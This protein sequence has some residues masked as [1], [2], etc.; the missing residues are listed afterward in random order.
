MHRNPETLTAYFSSGTKLLLPSWLLGF[1]TRGERDT[2][3]TM[4][5]VPT[6]PT[7]A[8]RIP[9]VTNWTR[10]VQLQ[11]STRFVQ[12]QISTHWPNKRAAHPVDPKLDSP[13]SES[14]LTGFFQNHQESLPIASG[15]DVIHIP[16]PF[17]HLGFFIM[18]SVIVTSSAHEREHLHSMCTPVRATKPNNS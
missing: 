2:I 6:D 18:T 5:T 15:H 14:Q 1:S 9:L 12:H 3:F 11:I 17:S 13:R 8:R 4:L 10:L 7:N 16:V